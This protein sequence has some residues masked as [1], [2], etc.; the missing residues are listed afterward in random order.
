[1]HAVEDHAWTPIEWVSA[2]QDLYSSDSQDLFSSGRTL[3]IQPRMVHD[4]FLA[5]V[6]AELHDLI[7]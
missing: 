4:W 1:M 5:A 6:T 3:K 7:S 2:N